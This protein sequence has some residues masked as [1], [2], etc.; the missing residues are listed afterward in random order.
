MNAAQVQTTYGSTIE[1]MA[2]VIGVPS[3]VGGVSNYVNLVSGIITQESGGNPNAIGDN[4]CSYGL[5]QLN[6]CA[7][8][9]QSYGYDSTRDN[10]LDP[11]TNINYGCQYLNMLLNRYGNVSQA[12][13]AYNAGS[14]TT[15]NQ[16]YVSNVIAYMRQLGTY[17]TSN[18]IVLIA[19]LG[20]GILAFWYF[21]NQRKKK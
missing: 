9:L 15:I 17:I 13:S 16:N 2:G 7:G 14:P 8:W 21:S 12:V 4:G 6:T 5:M 3:V 11:A 1:S 19:M 20:T 10:L 18:P